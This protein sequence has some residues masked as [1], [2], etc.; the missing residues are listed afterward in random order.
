MD[1]SPDSENYGRFA[2]QEI[3]PTLWNP[4]LHHHV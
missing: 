1:Q 3:S 4:T 2:D